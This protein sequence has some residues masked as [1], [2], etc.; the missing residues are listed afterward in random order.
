MDLI[1]KTINAL[2]KVNITDWK[3]YDLEN[4]KKMTQKLKKTFG[5]KNIKL[6]K[7]L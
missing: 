2:E 4:G 7:V 1:K 3:A 5:A 6:I